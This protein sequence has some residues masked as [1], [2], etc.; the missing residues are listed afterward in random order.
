MFIYRD[1]C[2]G[3]LVYKWSNIERFYLIEISRKDSTK[4]IVIIWILRM[5]L[6]DMISSIKKP[7]MIKIVLTQWT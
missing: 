4:T 7:M 1:K 3:K 6:L 2:F 5:H